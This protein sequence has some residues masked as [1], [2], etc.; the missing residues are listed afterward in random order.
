MAKDQL[1]Q[2]SK[3]DLA[4]WGKERGIKYFMIN[5]TDL[6][7]IQRTKLVPMRAIGRMQ[8]GGAGFAGFAGGMDYTPAHP[9]M[10][11][12]PDADMAIQIPWQP[13]VAWVPGNPVMRNEYS[14]QAPRNVLRRQIADAAELGLHFKIGVEPEFSLLNP[15][16]T[17]LADARDTRSKP[18]YDQ[19]AMMRNLHVIR[20]ISE[21]MHELGW[22]S[23]QNDHEDANGQWEM[24]WDFDD[25][26]SMVDQLSFFKF[27]VKH[28]AEKHGMRASFM[29]KPLPT[30]TGNGLHVHISAWDAPGEAARTNHFAGDDDTPTGRYGL[31][32][33]GKHFLGGVIKHGSA[34][35]FICCPTVNSYK[36]IGAATTDSG[37][38][39][40]PNR[41]T[42][43]GDNRTHLVRVPGGGR[44]ELRLPDGSA[45]PYLMP[46]AII[47]AGLDGIRTKADPGKPQEIDMHKDGHKVKGAPR[48]PQNML[49][50]LRA[51]DRNKVLKTRM[52]E[53]FSA[54]YLKLKMQEWNSF[55]SHFSRWEQEHTL[56]I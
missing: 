10:L 27:M 13:D 35:T 24:N 17:G 37:A 11:V 54:A 38:T 43:A 9:D 2:E 8:E 40:A 50:A 49:D 48:L 26:L 28:V 36:R 34:M 46:A 53:E 29:P 1:L 52:G 55:V 21:Y 30:L 45:N 23:Y 4:D 51:Y 56:D 44:M 14:A 7:G 41:V 39:W 32:E 18:C 20:E 33:T 6:F 42:W 5:F 19:Q 31:S 12:M 3:T 22:G 15:D 47:A 25:V 16:G